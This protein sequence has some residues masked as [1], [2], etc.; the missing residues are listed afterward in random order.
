MRSGHPF[1]TAAAAN[2]PPSAHH[3]SHLP[4]L[5]GPANTVRNRASPISMGYNFNN[6]TMQK[7]WIS[8]YS[9]IMAI[10]VT[11]IYTY[12]YSGFNHLEKYESQWE[13]LSHI[14]WKIKNV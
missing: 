12:I 8:I 1:S 13:G 10:I 6:D 4:L 5:V 9:D 11:Y 2:R 3:L 14:L 7:L